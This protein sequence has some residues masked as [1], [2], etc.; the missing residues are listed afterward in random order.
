M[1]G[2][3][4]NRLPK[5]PACHLRK[6]KKVT[7]RGEGHHQSGQEDVNFLFRTVT[8]LG[9][10]IQKLI[11]PAATGK[12]R[13]KGEREEKRHCKKIQDGRLWKLERKKEKK[14]IFHVRA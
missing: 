14:M 6:K 4:R 11:K 7:T 12:K 8:R 5:F 3:C 9:I 13:G 1:R 2:K 10:D